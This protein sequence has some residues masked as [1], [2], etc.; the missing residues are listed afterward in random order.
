VGSPVYDLNG[1]EL[2]RKMSG[3]TAGLGFGY[4]FPTIPLKAGFRYEH[5]FVSDDPGVNLISLRISYVIS[6]WKKE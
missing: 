5:V 2:D 3:I 6:F 1:N 4:L